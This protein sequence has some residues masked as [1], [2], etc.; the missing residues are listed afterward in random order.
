MSLISSLQIYNRRLLTERPFLETFLQE[1]TVT[2]P[3]VEPE[4]FLKIQMGEIRDIETFQRDPLHDYN[5]LGPYTKHSQ[6]AQN[7]LEQACF[8]VCPFQR[9]FSRSKFIQ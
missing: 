5:S 7:V 9:H 1:A 4:L 6:G 3:P 2:S 8:L